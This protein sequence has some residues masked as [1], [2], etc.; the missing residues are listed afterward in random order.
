MIR[1]KKAVAR[2]M[3]AICREVL[4]NVDVWRD[5]DADLV[6]ATES[7]FEFLVSKLDEV[8]EHN[9]QWTAKHGWR[10]VDE[11]VIADLEVDNPG[12]DIH[13]LLDDLHCQLYARRS[14]KAVKRV[15]N[16]FHFIK[17]KASLQNV[18]KRKYYVTRE[19]GHDRV[20][21]S[22]GDVEGG[23]ERERP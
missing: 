16:W 2:D 23:Q 21:R 17:A 14:T 15:K 18:N 6:D 19:S 10:G 3:L 22:V 11:Y 20:S 5:L 7:V 13:K 12:M 4:T 9:V 8:G 1:V